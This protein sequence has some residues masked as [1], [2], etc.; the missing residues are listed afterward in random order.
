LLGSLEKYPGALR[1]L[2]GVSSAD[3]FCYWVSATGNGGP[4]LSPQV[5][6]R[7]A[8]RELVLGFDIYYVPAKGPDARA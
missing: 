8:A 1:S 6:G 3:V 5:L 4:D 7:L 2:P